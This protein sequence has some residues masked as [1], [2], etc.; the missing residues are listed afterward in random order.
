[1]TLEGPVEMRRK[2]LVVPTVLSIDPTVA[3]HE[4][5][6]RMAVLLG[7]FLAAAAAEGLVVGIVIGRPL[8]GLIAFIAV[9]LCYLVVGARLGD[10]WIKHALRLEP[11]TSPDAE[12]LL[13][14]VASRSGIAVPELLRSAGD[15]PNGLALGLR[16]RWI[17]VTA[18]A[19]SL[20]RLE[21]EALLAHELAHLRD[22]DAALASAFVLVGGSIELAARSTGARGAVLAFIAVPV[23]PACV[24]VRALRVPLFGVDREHRADVVGALLTRYPPGMYHVL[25]RAGPGQG[26]ARLR[27]TDP[28]WFVPRVDVG[29]PDLARR[30]DLVEEM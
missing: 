19:E 21:L 6:R 13:S 24:V 3:W 8:T 28:F 12:S 9:A 23:W 25:R 15:A 17:A 2:D 7:V 14:A 16:R 10:R 27:S 26:P 5:R 20:D 18:G 30:A 22:G 29:G 4:N 11:A 1:M